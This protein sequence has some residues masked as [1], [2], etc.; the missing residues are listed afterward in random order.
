MGTM[1]AIRYLNVLLLCCGGVSVSAFAP[2]H[3]MVMKTTPRFST[4][5]S[6]DATIAKDGLIEAAQDFMET[7][8]GYY[9][10]LDMEKL[11]DDFIFRGPVIGRSLG[12]QDYAQVLDYFKKSTRPFLILSPIVLVSPLIHKIPI[13]SGSF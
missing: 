5:Q 9:S 13:V 11:A 7:C 2:F 3:R 8:T 4:T 10:P 6:Q 12:N 1:Q